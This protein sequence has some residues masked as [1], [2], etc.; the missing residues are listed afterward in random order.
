M[1]TIAF[2]PD[3]ALLLGSGDGADGRD[4]DYGQSSTPPNSCA[5]PPVDERRRAGGRTSEGGSLRSQ[6]L[7]TRSDP[8]SL[9][10][11]LLRIDRA[12]GDGLSDNPL[13]RR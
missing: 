6:D 9:D 12:T 5:D 3:G 10:G 7:R 11:T 4:I 13:G 8:L 2:G 1:G